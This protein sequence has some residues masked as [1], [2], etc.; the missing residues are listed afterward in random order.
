MIGEFEGDIRWEVVFRGCRVGPH[1]GVVYCVHYQARF[2]YHIEELTTAA[3]LVVVVGPGEAVQGRG[4]FVIKLIKA[5]E[6]P[7][8]LCL[9]VDRRRNRD[10]AAFLPQFLD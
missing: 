7:G 3:L 2:F 1:E 10:A 6:L 5:A 9:E 4:D 8:V